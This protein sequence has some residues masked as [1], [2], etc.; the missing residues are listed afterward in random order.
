[1]NLSAYEIPLLLFLQFR[2]MSSHGIPR[3]Q[4]DIVKTDEAKAKEAKYYQ[5]W[6][7]HQVFLVT[8]ETGK[9]KAIVAWSTK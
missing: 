7:R 4:Q 8:G 6:K 5:A 9:S 2:I 1:M 3:Y